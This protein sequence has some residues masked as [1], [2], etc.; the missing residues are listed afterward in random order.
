M[1]LSGYWRSRSFGG[2]KLFE[3]VAQYPAIGDE[4]RIRDRLLGAR[5]HPGVDFSAAGLMTS[6]LPNALAT[7][8]PRSIATATS[9]PRQRNSA[10]SCAPS[11]A[12]S[13]NSSRGSGRRTRSSASKPNCDAPGAPA[14]ESSTRS[15][16]PFS[17]GSRR[18]QTSGG[19]RSP[20]EARGIWPRR[21]MT[22]GR[23]IKVARDVRGW[24]GGLSDPRRLGASA[25][26]NAP[27]AASA[28]FSTLMTS[29]RPRLQRLSRDPCGSASTAPWA[30]TRKAACQSAP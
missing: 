2:N 18:R 22:R 14:R 24:G 17:S 26:E 30:A 6:A 9:R 27:V 12:A 21:V 16:A 1:R 5:S 25:D 4:A 8:C 13:R 23:R 29:G 7:R 15:G 28:F 3:F 19:T 10:S 20:H 11:G